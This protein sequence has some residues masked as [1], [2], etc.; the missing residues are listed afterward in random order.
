MSAPIYGDLPLAV[1]ARIARDETF[2]T[3]SEEAL[4]PVLRPW[5]FLVCG[6]MNESLAGS[7]IQAVDP[8]A[9]EKF[10]CRVN[11]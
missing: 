3:L 4:P 7:V 1:S 5:L 9:L 11:T 8:T 2:R 10:P 6:F